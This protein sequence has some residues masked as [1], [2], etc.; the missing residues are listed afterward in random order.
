MPPDVRTTRSRAVVN[1]VEPIL[2]ETQKQEP[3]KK[4]C[5]SSPTPCPEENMVVDQA[6][7]E[8]APA[9]D[10]AQPLSS[11]SSFAP[12][13][14]V[15]QAP[16]GLSAFKFNPLTP[17]TADAF[18]TPRSVGLHLCQFSSNIVIFFSF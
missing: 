18:L 16:S 15:F 3:E 17:R 7:V 5:P 14:F 10:S 6:S 2:K 12:E 4:P 9:V 1:H 13:G 11:L 8:S